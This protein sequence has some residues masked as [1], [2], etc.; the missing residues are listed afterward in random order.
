MGQVQDINLIKKQLL[1]GAFRNGSVELIFHISTRPFG[2]S[3]SRLFIDIVRFS[4]DILAAVI[5]CNVGPTGQSLTYRFVVFLN[6]KHKGLGAEDPVMEPPVERLG[7]PVNVLV[8]ISDMVQHLHQG[9]G[10]NRWLALAFYLQ[11]M[12]RNSPFPQ[13]GPSSGWQDPEAIDESDLLF[14]THWGEILDLATDALILHEH[15]V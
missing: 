7:R 10:R 6:A 2:Y 13:D 15:A 12:K 8:D 14:E 3:R 9:L 1:A 4:R 5:W 11:F